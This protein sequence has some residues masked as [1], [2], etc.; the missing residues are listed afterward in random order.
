MQNYVYLVLHYHFSF[1]GYSTWK[2]RYST[3][4]KI[5]I[6]SS[7]VLYIIFAPNYA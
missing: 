3:I 2:L 4:T 7:V 5:Q 1:F 6:H